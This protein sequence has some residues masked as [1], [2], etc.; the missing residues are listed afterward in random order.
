MK[1]WENEHELIKILQEEMPNPKLDA[2][3]KERMY[4]EFISKQQKTSKH[5]TQ[6]KW[7]TERMGI[8][9]HEF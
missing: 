1:T 4:H 9:I 8:T 6:V 2:V 3:S 5:L 7:I